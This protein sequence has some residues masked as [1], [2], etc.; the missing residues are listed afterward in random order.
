MA[1][2][3]KA[4][5]TNAVLPS[6]MFA[7]DETYSDD[8]TFERWLERF[9][10]QATAA[11]WTEAQ[12]LFQLESHLVKT[13]LHIVHMMP[14]AGKEQYATVVSTLKKWL[15]SLDIAELK[16]LEFHQLM[17]DR[18]SVD[19]L[20]VTLQK[21]AVKAFPES[22]AKKFDR[23]PKGRFYQALLPKWQ[24]K[25]GAPKTDES[26]ENL[27]SRTRAIE[28]HEQQFN[29]GR[30]DYHRGR[31]AVEYAKTSDVTAGVQWVYPSIENIE[32]EV[33]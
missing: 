15:R 19:D 1:V 11:S 17:Q 4:V 20:G 16:G 3:I 21:L 32:S 5:A 13:A 29:S 27:F 12:N 18:Q 10:D 23:M 2:Q 22:G 7:G 26:F 25:L 6:P 30:R 31:S 14:K 33:S 8:A 9:E 24:R 28:R